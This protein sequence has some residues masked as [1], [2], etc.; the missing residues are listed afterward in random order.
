MQ[1]TKMTWCVQTRLVIF[2]QFII[3]LAL[4]MSDPYWPLIISSTHVFNPRALQYWSGIIYMAPLLTMI[5]TTVLW[6]KIGERVGYK[7]MLLRAGLALAATQWSLF[8]FSNLWVILTIRLL[9][10][11]LAGFSTAAQ[12]WSLAITPIN[13]HGQ[14]VGRLQAATAMGSIVGPICGGIISHYYGYLSIFITAGCLCLFLSLI[15]ANFLQENP[16]QSISPIV[17]KTQKK[18][19]L[20]ESSK[21]L[22]LLLIVSTQVAR[23]MSTPFFALYVAQQLHADNLTLGLIYA[24]MALSMSLMTSVLGKTID[25]QPNH[26]WA[27]FLLIM[28]LLVSGLSQWG[29]AF[30]SKSY[31]AFALSILWGLS[32][33]SIAVILFSFLLKNISDS[34]RAKA[35]GLGNTALKFGNLIGIIAGT[36]IQAEEIQLEGQFMVSFIVIGSFY[37]FL[38]VL[39]LRYN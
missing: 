7:I 26:A 32:L 39:S 15:L 19:F 20:E 28:A 38:A 16:I 9:Q 37:F 33:G 6:I 14:I 31:I 24:I 2:A 29:F 23:W 17:K 35:V 1:V 11:G 8:F 25:K 3:I 4:D 5:F 10:G 27:K 34:N 22:L 12:A 13:T 21:N 36:L 18:F 30:I